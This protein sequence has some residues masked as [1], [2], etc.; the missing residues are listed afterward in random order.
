MRILQVMI[1]G[2]LKYGGPPQKIFALSDGLVKRGYEVQI[3]TFH[4]ERPRGSQYKNSNGVE[5]R[6]LSW[7]GRGLWQIPTDVKKLRA[8][9]RQSDIVHCYGLYNLLCPLAILLARFASRPYI[10]EPLGMYVPRARSLRG[11]ALYHRLF[12]SKMARDAARV[13]A[14]S[15]QEADELSSLVESEKLVVRRNGIDLSLYRELP[16]RRAFRAR[17]NISESE[18]IVIYVG[19]ISPIKNLEQLVRAFRGASLS[20]T[21]LVLVGPPLEPDYAA[22]LDA[23]IEELHLEDRVLLTGPLYKDDKLAALAA[24]DL[25]VLPSLYESYGNAAAEAVAAGVPVLLTE[26]C[27]IAPQ[28]HGRAGLAVPVTETALVDGLRT[29]LDNLPQR[30]ALTAQRAEALKE[31]SWEEPLQLTEQMYQAISLNPN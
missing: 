8:M 2:E 20:H 5:V 18:R 4:S 7:I 3:A 22:R 30:A 21:R 19:R 9:V 31:L 25:F 13:V 10:L 17:Y 1:Y 28:I 6:Y 12:T 16:D 29:M 14:T 23:L 27:G 15:G 26:T 24:A 11:K